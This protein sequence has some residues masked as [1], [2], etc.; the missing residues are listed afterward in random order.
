MSAQKE[1]AV[2]ATSTAAAARHRS[3]LVAAIGAFAFWGV[4]P[5]YLNLLAAVPALEILAHRIVWCCVFVIGWVAARGELGAI[6]AALA[7]RGTRLR[8]A[9]T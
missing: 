2:V 8:L 4:F 5:L 6:R 9:A 1:S 7:N 3:G